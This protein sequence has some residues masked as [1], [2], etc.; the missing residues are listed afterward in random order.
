MLSLVPVILGLFGWL[1][2]FGALLLGG[3]F[4]LLALSLLPGRHSSAVR[5]D[6]RLYKYSLLYLALLFTLMTVDRLLRARWGI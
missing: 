2:A 3:Q 1:Y 4:A 5:A 6:A